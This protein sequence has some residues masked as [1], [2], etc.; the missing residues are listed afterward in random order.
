MG[1]RRRFNLPGVPQHVIQRGNN[2]EACFYS[3]EDYAAYLEFLK[4]AAEKAKCQLHA[5]ILMTNHVHMLVTPMQEN[6]I[7]TMMQSLGKRY[8]QYINKVYKKQ[9][10]SDTIF[11]VKSADFSEVST[12]EKLEPVRPG[13]IPLE[14]LKDNDITSNELANHINVPEPMLSLF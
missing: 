5:Y 6:S 7:P 2:R 10:V 14:F 4:I 11:F 3:E 1:R 13:G 12:G 9:L 8:V